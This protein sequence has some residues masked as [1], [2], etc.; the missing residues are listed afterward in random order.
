MTSLIITTHTD[1]FSL[2]NHPYSH[3]F[4]IG[5]CCMSMFGVFN[6]GSLPTKTALRLFP[7]IQNVALPVIVVSLGE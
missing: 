7:S 6:G 5:E 2:S 3:F 4:V 1:D